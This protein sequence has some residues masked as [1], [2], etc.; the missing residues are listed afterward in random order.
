MKNTDTANSTPNQL[1]MRLLELLSKG[2]TSQKIADE[3]GYEAG[4]I[5][6]YLHKLYRQL[7]VLNRTQAVTWW[8]DFTGQTITKASAASTNQAMLK[9]LSYGER[10][11]IDGLDKPLGFFEMYL[12]PYSRAWELANMLEGNDEGVAPPKCASIVRKLWNAFL[13]GDFEYAKST[14][15]KGYLQRIFLESP[16]DAALLTAMLIVGGYSSRANR[17]LSSLSI[18]K[19]GEGGLLEIEHQTMT[20]IWSAA[21]TAKPA[22]FAALHEHLAS[23]AGK[24]SMVFRHMILA[25]LFH[26]YRSHGDS[27]RASAIADCL[28][29]DAEKL[30]QQL[31]AMGDWPQVN[32]LPKAP[33]TIAR[34]SSRSKVAD[35]VNA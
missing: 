7:D 25:S 6:V 31:S 16:S 11:V 35:L 1:Q 27:V 5:R 32:A 34:I 4:T 8:L 15:D 10:A 14:Y 19:K 33:N 2:F 23:S 17:S 22:A 20:A 21:E 13:A 18:A 29:Q 3:T 26:L 9:H 12:G 28:L 30:R 24:L